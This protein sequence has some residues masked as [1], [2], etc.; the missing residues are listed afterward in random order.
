MAPNDF[1]QLIKK[2]FSL[3]AFRCRQATLPPGTVAG[4]YAVKSSAKP[5][6]RF[7]MTQIAP[8][9]SR[10]SP[11]KSDLDVTA[12]HLTHVAVKDVVKGVEIATPVR[13]VHK[14]VVTSS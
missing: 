11:D 7:R 2:S 3:S 4:V 9:T 8:R 1:D 14:F 6:R 13:P 5:P 10:V 12:R